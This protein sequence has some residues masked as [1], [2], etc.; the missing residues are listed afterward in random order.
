MI[1]AGSIASRLDLDIN[2]FIT[3]MGQAKGEADTFQ[4]K[5]ESTGGK[6]QSIGKTMTTGVT[7]PLVAM[8]TGMVKTTADFDYG[9]SKVQAL[10]GATGE[11]MEALRAKA[12]EMGASTKF[13]ASESAEALGYMGM[14]GW[15]SA[16]MIDALPGVM[17]LAA[18]SGEELGLVSDIVTDAMTAFGMEASQA[19]HFADVL[20]VA[21]SKSNTNV[22]LL[23]ESFK[24]VA[25]VAG[26]LGYSAEDTAMA[27]GLMANA[28]IKG[29]QAGTS[30]RGALLRLASP[31]GEVADAMYELG[32]EMFNLDGSAKP[33][34]EVIAQLRDGF[35]GLTD[36]E[37]TA[38]AEA[39]FGQQAVAG[40]LSI[41]NAGQDDVDGLSD[42]INN[43]GGAAE[44]MA[45]T[46][47]DNLTGQITELKSQLEGVAIGLGEQLVPHLRD[48]VKWI[49]GMV[50]KF[51]SLSP[52]T[53]GTI[54]KFIGLAAAAGPVLTIVGGLM[55][56]VGALTGL[57]AAAGPAAGAAGA[58]LGGVGTA[59]GTAAG[60]TGI[61][62]LLSGFGGVLATVAPFV[63]GIGAVGL[64]GYGLY[65]TLTDEAIP[66]VDLFGDEVSE[67][68]AQA[69]QGYLDLEK[70][71]TDALKQLSWSGQEVTA[72]MAENIG[73]TFAEMKDTI[74]TSLE[75]QKEE[76]EAV[77]QDMFDNAAGMSSAQKDKILQM[78]DD[79]YNEKNEIVTQGEEQI[80]KIL[81]NASENKRAL[82]ESEKTEINRIQE[83]MRTVAVK[84]LSDSEAEQMAIMESL[85]VNATNLSARQAA[86]VVKNSKEQK[87]KTI[88]EAEEEY[89]ERL[90][91]AAQLRAKGTAEAEEMADAIVTEATRQ[92]DEAVAMAEDMHD[93]VVEEAKAQAEEHVNE[94]D[95]ETGEILTKWDTFARD[96]GVLWGGIKTKAGEIWNSISNVVMDANEG[97]RADSERSYRTAADMADNTWETITG[98]IGRGI[99]KLLEWNRTPVQNKTSTFTTVRTTINE[100]YVRPTR[101][102]YAHG[103]NWASGGWALVGEQGPEYVQLPQGSK[104]H[105]NTKTKQMMEIDYERLGEEVAKAI[106]KVPISANAYLDG[107]NI[108]ANVS[109]RMGLQQRGLAY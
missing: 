88:A 8:G 71:A 61:G 92:R 15:N 3:K 104:V 106:A 30:L 81:D 24:Y 62:A 45:K 107:K 27:L 41:I 53:Q 57:F 52:E 5:M 72:E 101:Q 49:Q 89:Q 108:T 58:A 66:A 42:S 12:K 46:M 100:S 26:S 13:S 70:E 38:F 67:S 76:S 43:A 29:S 73:G 79:E 28:G 59:A 65:K 78:M 109:R 2:P 74:I 21:S 20:A 85:K 33:L 22:G 36:A 50:D 98:A 99:N 35:D 25:P 4:S 84:T 31:T 18:A 60:A 44:K 14:A 64:A 83:E 11:E 55:K 63:L 7:L 80:Q 32:I 6:L 9:M 97:M 68:T 51:A 47:E 105:S 23:G 56:G 10:S 91:A 48:A 40:M 37:Q 90:K 69:V 96:V 39:L 82:T 94:V 75:T 87:E 1:D 77:L 86:D 16:Q 17:N 93:R 19:A 95:W 102:M 54:L 103:T 34:D